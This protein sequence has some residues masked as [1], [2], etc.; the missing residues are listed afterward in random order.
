MKITKG[1]S[2]LHA[3]S[4]A[5]ALSLLAGANRPL[6]AAPPGPVVVSAVS[7]SFNAVTRH[8]DPGGSFYLYVSTEPWLEGLSTKVGAWRQFFLSI[9]GMSDSDRENVNKAF[10]LGSNLIKESGVED[11][12][13]LGMSGVLLDAGLYRTKVMVHHYPNQNRGFLWSLFG[14]EPHPFQELSFLPANTAVSFCSDLDLALLWTVLEREV[15]R[16]ELAEASKALRQ[17]KETVQKQTGVEFEKVLASLSGPFLFVLTLDEE[18]KVPI[19]G[20]KDVEISEP[21]LGLMVRVKNDVLFKSLER[22]LLQQEQVIKVDKPDLRMRTMPLPLPF[23]VRPTIAQTGDYLILATH[24]GLVED[25]LAVAQ[26]QHPGL[27]TTAEFKQLSAG[28]PLEGNQF[29]YLSRRFG[30]ELNQILNGIVKSQAGP[31]GPSAN[32]LGKMIGFDQVAF[33]V[34]SSTKEGWLT[35]ANRNEHP[36]TLIAGPVLVAPV[37]VMASMLLPAL[38]KAKSKAQSINCMS[39]MKQIGLAARLYA[40]DHND[41]FPKSYTDMKEEL[42]TPKIL[43]CP[44]DQ[45][46]RPAADWDHY[47]PEHNLSY[48]F[49]APGTK[50]YE[51]NVVVFRCPVHGHVGLADGSVRQPKK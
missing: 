34:T 14:T 25:M 40:N 7:N 36:A 19:P 4:F 27:Q 15:D 11:V 9:P 47:D 42:V 46:K 30:Q 31:A 3:L 50:G 18:K 23:P 6:T 5:A 38:A 26:G 17:W 45:T 22:P 28:I 41:V 33:G 48:E 29:N 51:S 10:Q 24:E 12:S 2:S 16:S 37:A 21:R 32:F 1:P 20:L 8:L 43:A 49:V 35:T 39:N 13:G 44:S